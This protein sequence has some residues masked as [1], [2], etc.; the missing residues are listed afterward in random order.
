MVVEDSTVCF[1]PRLIRGVTCIHTLHP[2]IEIPNARVCVC[3]TIAGK[4]KLFNKWCASIPYSYRGRFFSTAGIPKTP[5]QNV[6]VEK[7]WR[8]VTI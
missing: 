7:N 8:F 5:C 4:N 6:G 2:D 3:T 1:W